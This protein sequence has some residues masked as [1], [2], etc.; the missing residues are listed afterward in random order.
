MMECSYLLFLLLDKQE[1]LDVTNRNET[2]RE[3]HTNC[4]EHNCVGEVSSPIPDT[5]ERLLVVHMISPANEIRH[6]QQEAHNLHIRM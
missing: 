6:L 1:N 5:R 2:Y 4:R 3:C